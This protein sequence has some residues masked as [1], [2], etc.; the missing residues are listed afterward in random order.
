MFQHGRRPLLLAAAA[1]QVEACDI[2]ILQ[3]AEINQADS[4]CNSL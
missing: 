3:G 1:G 4:V 2:L